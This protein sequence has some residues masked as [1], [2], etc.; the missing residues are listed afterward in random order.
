MTRLYEVLARFL[1][2]LAIALL[3]ITAF[4]TPERAVRADYGSDA[5]DTCASNYDGTQNWLDYM[6]TCCGDACA[7]DPITP[8]LNCMPKCQ[9]AIQPASRCDTGCKAQTD[10]A[11]NCGFFS[12][13]TYCNALATCKENYGC[14]NTT[15][16]K[17]GDFPPCNC[18]T[19]R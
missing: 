12:A 9:A 7:N 2:S 11:V 1:G 6:T 14:V 19:V 16:G 4:I 3:G 5:G 10:P 13:A 18:N 17:T 15:S 8:D